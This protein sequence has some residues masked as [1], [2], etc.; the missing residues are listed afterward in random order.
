MDLKKKSV[1]DKLVE[2]TAAHLIADH[3]E[4]RKGRGLHDGHFCCR[5]RRSCADDIVWCAKGKGDQAVV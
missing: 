1:C 2:R 3:M 5:V 4:R